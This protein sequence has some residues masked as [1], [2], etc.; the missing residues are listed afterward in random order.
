MKI[1]PIR[2]LLLDFLWLDR[3][4]FN[5]DTLADILPKI[6]MNIYDDSEIVEEYMNEYLTGDVSKL[7]E[8]LEEMLYTGT[9]LTGWYTFIDRYG[10]CVYMPINKFGF[11]KKKGIKYARFN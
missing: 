7:K 11:I 3:S 4:A 6:I 10:I 5:K 2:R 1:S 8:A 9:T